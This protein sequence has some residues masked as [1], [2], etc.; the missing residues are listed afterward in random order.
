[1]IVKQ[2]A[3]NMDPWMMKIGVGKEKGEVDEMRKEVV[4]FFVE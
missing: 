4:A 1:V 3:E 2:I